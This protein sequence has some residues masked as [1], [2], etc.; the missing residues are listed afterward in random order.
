M[1]C[2]FN[3]HCFLGWSPQCTDTRLYSTSIH[4]SLANCNKSFYAKDSCDSH[5]KGPPR[6][7]F[8][9]TPRLPDTWWRAESQLS[10]LHQQKLAVTFCSGEEEHGRICLFSFF[11]SISHILALQHWRALGSR[12]QEAARLSASFEN[13]PPGTG[14]V[15]VASHTIQEKVRLTPSKFKRKNRQPTNDHIVTSEISSVS[16]PNLPQQPSLLSW[17]VEVVLKSVFHNPYVSN[18]EL[19][20]IH[21][22]QSLRGGDNFWKLIKKWFLRRDTISHTMNFDKVHL[23]QR[24]DA[25]VLL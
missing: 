13:K 17:L 16:F 24:S 5:R 18:L 7:R 21:H 6:Y 4:F 12:W 23:P 8:D 10:G 20:E 3:C 15:N 19:R 22:L 1:S 11:T 9:G 14:Q 2:Q 25:I